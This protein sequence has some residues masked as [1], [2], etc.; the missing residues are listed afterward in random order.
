MIARVFTPLQAFSSTPLIF[1]FFRLMLE[2]ML[3]LALI[4]PEEMGGSRPLIPD[5]SYLFLSN[6]ILFPHM[7]SIARISPFLLFIMAPCRP[8]HVD[9]EREV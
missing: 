5:V 1:F 3:I 8:R 7:G 4:F 9:P 6:M 2:T